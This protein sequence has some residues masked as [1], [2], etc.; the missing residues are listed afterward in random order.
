MKI[1]LNKRF[2]FG[3]YYAINLFGL[4]VSKRPL[5]ATE[6]NHE[7][8]HTLQQRELLWI[9]FYIWYGVEWLIRLIAARSLKR[10]YI[11]LSFEREAYRNQNDLHYPSHRP[12]WAWRR[13]IKH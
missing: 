6:R 1:I 3:S 10:A 5:T 11:T 4:I 12:F 2:P 7:Y 9:G 13:H 8:I